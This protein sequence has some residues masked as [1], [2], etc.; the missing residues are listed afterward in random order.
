MII[1]SALFCVP[2]GISKVIFTFFALFLAFLPSVLC[3]ST[4]GAVIKSRIG[5]CA[6][7]RWM[8]GKEQ[9]LSKREGVHVS[10]P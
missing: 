7:L 6:L 4:A 3:C 5:L 10:G 8:P 2:A 9:K 1:V